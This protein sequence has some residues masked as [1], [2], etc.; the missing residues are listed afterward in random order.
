M[1]ADR[2]I[3]ALAFVVL[4]APGAASSGDPHQEHSHARREL[5]I[6]VAGD[7]DE[8]VE[9]A[10]DLEVGESRQLFTDSGKEVLVTRN[11]EGYAIEVDGKSI[12]VEVGDDSPAWFEKVGDGTMEIELHELE[13]GGHGFFFATGDDDEAVHEVRLH[14]ESALE[15]LLASGVLDEVDAATRQKIIDTLKEIERP[16]IVSKKVIVVRTGEDDDKDDTP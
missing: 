11:E 6:L 15:H 12:E 9:I 5:K 7:P 3:L 4:A 2:W 16:R 1:R 13:D 8:A 14:R 10:N